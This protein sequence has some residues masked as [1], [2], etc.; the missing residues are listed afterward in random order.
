MP[1][2]RCENIRIS[3]DTLWRVF[4]ILTQSVSC[5]F[6]SVNRRNNEVRNHIA[7]WAAACKLYTE[8]SPYSIRGYKRY[9]Y[10]VRLLLLLLLLRRCRI[11]GPRSADSRCF[12]LSRRSISTVIANRITETLVSFHGCYR[13]LLDFQNTRSFAYLRVRLPSIISATT[14][15][16]VA[17]SMTS[18][19]LS[20]APFTLEINFEINFESEHFSHWK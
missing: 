10:S 12:Y 11:L 20:K 13:L 16:H 17:T 18:V 14:Y 9:F 15:S 2:R 7:I 3:T 4:H 1:Y 19:R 6:V 5:T 8:N